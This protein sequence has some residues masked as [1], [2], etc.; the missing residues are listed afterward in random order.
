MLFS[1]YCL[2]GRDIP[3]VLSTA[4]EVLGM[5]GFTEDK[6]GAPNSCAMQGREGRARICLALSLEET[7]TSAG[8][9]DKPL[10][11]VLMSPADEQIFMTFCCSSKH[12]IFRPLLMRWRTS[13]ADSGESLCEA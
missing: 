10:S 1:E 9:S 11:A 5:T 7:L 3:Q 6:V 8:L 2:Y 12:G 13:L 4:H